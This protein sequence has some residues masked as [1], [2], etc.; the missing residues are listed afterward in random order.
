M[1]SEFEEASLRDILHHIDL[2]QQFTAGQDFEAFN[3]DTL[4]IYAVIRCL[5]VIS[6][7]SRRLSDDLRARHPTIAWKEM[8]GAGNVYRHDYQD[9]ASRRVWDT[10]RLALPPLRMVIV[11]EL[12]RSTRDDS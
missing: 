10:V 2:V 9:V 5:E 12:S 3:A 6:E 1:P 7:A 4:R 11:S 8:A